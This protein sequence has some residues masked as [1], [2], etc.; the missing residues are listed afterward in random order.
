[1]VKKTGLLKLNYLSAIDG[2]GREDLF[3]G[4]DEDNIATP[5]LET[6]YMLG[7]WTYVSRIMLVC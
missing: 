5:S 6:E 2:V 3:Y 7:F 4:Y 1:M